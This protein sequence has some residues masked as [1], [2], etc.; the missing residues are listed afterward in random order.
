[1]LVLSYQRNP[2]IQ[3]TGADQIP[4]NCSILGFGAW[5]LVLYVLFINARK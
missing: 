4:M 2:K 5:N 3:S 1:M